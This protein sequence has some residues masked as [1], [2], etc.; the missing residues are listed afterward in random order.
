MSEAFIQTTCVQGIS[1][2]TLQPKTWLHFYLFD[3][4]FNSMIILQLHY[5]AEKKTEKWN[6]I[7]REKNKW[8]AVVSL[9]QTYNSISSQWRTK[10][11]VKLILP[12]NKVFKK[13]YHKFGREKW[14]RSELSINFGEHLDH[15]KWS[16]K[17]WG[18]AYFT[19]FH[20]FPIL[21]EFQRYFL[22]FVKIYYFKIFVFHTND[23]FF[24]EY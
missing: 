2:K 23:Q 14:I 12:S 5:Y 7:L 6:E 15:K 3:T 8:V 13:Q 18:W 9:N 1:I 21:S 24:M 20:F 11:E 16:K 19:H 22:Q 10:T 17:N 4:D